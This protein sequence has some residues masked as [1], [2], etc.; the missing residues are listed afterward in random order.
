MKSSL[1][2]VTWRPSHAT[3][4]QFFA[5]QHYMTSCPCY[6]T[7]SPIYGTTHEIVFTQHCMRYSPNATLHKALFTLI[8]RTLHCM[9]FF[10][11]QVHQ[12]LSTIYY[13]KA[14]ISYITWRL[15]HAILHEGL[16]TLHYINAFPEYI[17]SKPFHVALYEGPSFHAP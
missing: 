4:H 10:H 12:G 11:A 1:R 15:F 6:L 16:S 3:L 14:F 8:Y 9:F 2:Y 5:A 13:M 17:R 7:W